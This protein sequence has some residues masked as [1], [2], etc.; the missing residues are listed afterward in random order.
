VAAIRARCEPRHMYEPPP[1]ISQARSS[2]APPQILPSVS[3][4]P[5]LSWQSNRRSTQR[6][7]V[8]QYT[9]SIPRHRFPASGRQRLGHSS[10]PQRPQRDGHWVA[11][12]LVKEGSR[13][14]EVATSLTRH[15]L[16][17]ADDRYVGRSAWIGWR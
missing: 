4:A 1:S 17:T 3:Q 15:C 8:W 12:G 9:Q 5:A 7:S 14:I 16:V 10:R 6:N 13:H 11:L 2:N